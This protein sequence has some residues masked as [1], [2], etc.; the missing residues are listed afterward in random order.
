M[1]TPASEAILNIQEE[2]F[3]RLC[4]DKRAPC[5]ERLQQ[6]EHHEVEDPRDK[7]ERNQYG[8]KQGREGDEESL[9]KLIQVSQKGH[10]AVRNGSDNDEDDNEQTFFTV[11]EQWEKE[12]RER[13]SRLLRRLGPVF[14]KGQSHQEGRL[15]PLSL[16]R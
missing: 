14:R 9:P 13:A 3:R 12:A 4:V 2:G 10:R 11:T 7:G 16:F 15:H 8:D 6:R 1:K 5:R